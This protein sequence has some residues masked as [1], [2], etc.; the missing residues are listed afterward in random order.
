ML[1]TVF[2]VTAAGLRATA[3]RFYFLPGAWNPLGAPTKV[4]LYDFTSQALL[5]SAVYAGGVP[6]AA[7]WTDVPIASVALATSSQYVAAV[8][9]PFGY[10][11]FHSQYFHLHTQTTGPLTAPGDDSPPVVNNGRFVVATDLAFPSDSFG[12]TSYFADVV[13]SD[14][15]DVTHEVRSWAS[16][17]TTRVRSPAS[18]TSSYETR[19]RLLGAW[20]SAYVCRGRVAQSWA[21]SSTTRARAA[22]SWQSGWATDARGLAGWSSGYAVNAHPTIR[23]AS[24]YIVAS[25]MIVLEA[26]RARAGGAVAG[27]AGVGGEVAEHD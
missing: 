5:A 7:G 18:W 12:N 24:S 14:V 4:A 27:R 16:S 8:L 13:V 17:W 2:Q 20:S 26:G 6:G 25:P 23:W 11:P 9:Y 3:I 1:G 19:Q 10:Y 21:S 15:P 22:A